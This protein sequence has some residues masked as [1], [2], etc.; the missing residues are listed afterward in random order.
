L[1]RLILEDLSFVIEE[2]NK[3]KSR[4]I[5]KLDALLTKELKAFRHLNP[6]LRLSVIERG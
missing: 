2:F 6:R 4:D 5:S 1:N 3:K